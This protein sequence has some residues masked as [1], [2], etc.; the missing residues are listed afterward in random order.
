LTFCALFAGRYSCQGCLWCLR[1][2][3]CDDS[4]QALVKSTA[5]IVISCG[6]SVAAVN[7]VVSRENRAK[8]I[9]IM[10]PSLLGLSRFDLV[11]IPRHDRPPERKNVVATEGSLN[12]IDGAYL[13]EQA[14]RLRQSSSHQVIKSPGVG[15]NIGLL[16]GGDTKD[17]YLDKELLKT[18][19]AQVK[20][21]AEKADA[22]VLITTSR[23]TNAAAE[24]LVKDEFKGYPRCRLMVI[25]SEDN[26]A[27]AVGGI[28]GV[29]RVVVI[30]PE[31]TS[32]ISE[33]ASSGR[34]VVVF[35]APVSRRH[36][37][38]L[39]RLAQKGHIYLAEPRELAA[40]INKINI[41]QPVVSVLK[42][43]EILKKALD[44][45]I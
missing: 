4:Y 9:V 29:S 17:F 11:V 45:I 41:E 13:K 10:R 39:N 35:N 31:S 7:Y 44:R 20:T 14:E 12:L 25:A 27:Y 38:F 40:L 22:A 37:I 36:R 32:M 24:Q 28:L 43:K 6:S 2:F 42:D 30:S 5:D 18:T 19:I 26:P 23:R 8:S 3:I 33:A 16:I 1:K 21:V 15:F 34:Y